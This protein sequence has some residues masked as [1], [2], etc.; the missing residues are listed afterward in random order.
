LFLTVFGFCFFYFEISVISP[1]ERPLALRTF[2][3]QFNDWSR[4]SGPG[5][6]AGL[7]TFPKRTV[8]AMG[9]RRG[10]VSMMLNLSGG[11]WLPQTT[12]VVPCHAI[13]F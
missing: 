9:A 13:F 11:F 6:T 3:S 10:F 4:E 1:S 5:N 7:K 8:F 12:V 2:F